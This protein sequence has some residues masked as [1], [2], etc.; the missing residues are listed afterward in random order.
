MKAPKL[1]LTARPITERDYRARLALYASIGGAIALTGLVVGVIL[2][3][4]LG[5]WGI[6]T[7]PERIK[8]LSWAMLGALAIVGLVI[9]GLGTAINK[10]IVKG[11]IGAASFEASGGDDPAPSATVTT[12]VTQSTTVPPPP[13]AE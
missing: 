7:A 8:A 6:D 11:E 1:D 4:W 12:T 2:I 10:R 13:P 9:I 5:A 3:L